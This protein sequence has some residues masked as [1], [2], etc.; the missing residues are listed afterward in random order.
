M[1]RYVVA[2][3]ALT[4]LGACDPGAGSPLEPSTPSSVSLAPESSSPADPVVAATRVVQELLADDE[5]VVG[6]A[7]C[8]ELFSASALEAVARTWW[9]GAVELTTSRT[10]QVGAPDWSPALWCDFGPAKVVVADRDLQVD[11]AD[12]FGATIVAQT[13]MGSGQLEVARGEISDGPAACVHWLSQ[14]DL[15]VLISVEGPVTPCDEAALPSAEGAIRAVIE[16]L[17]DAPHD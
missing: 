2:T 17:S 16:S 1:R 7:A 8:A 5:D 12:D 15:T 4:T 10:A 11:A 14:S 13:V 3:I 9:S 6:S